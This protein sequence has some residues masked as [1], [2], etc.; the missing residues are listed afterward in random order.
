[1]GAEIEAGAQAGGRGIGLMG[2]MQAQLSDGL[3]RGAEEAT[4][5]AERICA[6]LDVISGQLASIAGEEEE[7]TT[8]M[9]AVAANATEQMASGRPGYMGTIERI[10]VTGDGAT[11]VDIFV[12]SE[13]DTG[14]RHRVELAAAGRASAA[15]E[16]DV[17]ESASVFARAGAAPARVNLQIKRQH[18]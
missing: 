13:S 14:F 16:I 18:V 5:Y 9:K 7:R 8:A 2:R 4:I 6:R 15:V 1:M 12:G 3:R 10:A 11:T 17:P